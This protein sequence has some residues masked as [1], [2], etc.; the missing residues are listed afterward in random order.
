[1][2]YHSEIQ[3]AASEAQGVLAQIQGMSSASGATNC[4]LNGAEFVAVFGSPRVRVIMNPGGSY[5]KIV[6]V[7]ALLTRAQFTQPPKSEQ[8]LKRTDLTPHQSYR[9]ARVEDHDPHYYGLALVKVGE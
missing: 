9:V 3:A 4:I 1:M 2:S 8:E 6:E 5:R 7:P